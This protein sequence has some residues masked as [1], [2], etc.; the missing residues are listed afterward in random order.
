MNK[1]IILNKNVIIELLNCVIESRANA[2]CSRA[3]KVALFSVLYSQV[4]CLICSQKQ[5][6]N[7]GPAVRVK[8]LLFPH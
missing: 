4:T 7:A 5:K 6:K 8:S 3:F 2:K 1:I